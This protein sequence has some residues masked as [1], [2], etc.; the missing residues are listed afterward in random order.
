MSLR[1]LGQ[2]DGTEA[3][4]ASCLLLVVAYDDVAPAVSGAVGEAERRL[5]LDPALGDFIEL[6]FAALGPRSPR[7]D[8]RDTVDMRVVGELTRPTREAPENY[9]GLVV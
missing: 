1:E 5:L 4:W 7:D 6:R 9:F 2:Q 3:T 8:E